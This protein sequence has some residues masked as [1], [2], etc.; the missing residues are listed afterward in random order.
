MKPYLFIITVILLFFSSC[1]TKTKKENLELK[2]RIA[3]LEQEN[4]AYRKKEVK[5]NSSIKDYRKFLKGLNNNLKEI[6]ISSSIIGKLDSEINKDANIQ[7]EIKS[8]LKAVDELIKNSKLKIFALDAQLN[9]LR[10]ASREKSEEIL[11]LEAELGEAIL[12][13]L[14]RENEYL[15]ISQKLDEQV[16]LTKDLNAILNRAYYYIGYPKELKEK[17]IIE[18]EGGFIGLGRVKVINANAPDSLFTQIRKDEMDSLLFSAKKI[19]LVTPHPENS[20]I[21]KSKNYQHALVIKDKEK[22]WATGNY[23]II[24]KY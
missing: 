15:E 22:F 3:V 11:A 14:K 4:E 20:F 7:S 18:N 1:Q 5:L 17:G 19:E 23:L 12:D 9:A 21:I 16:A 6:D 2:E 8:R 13:L 10:K 24:Q